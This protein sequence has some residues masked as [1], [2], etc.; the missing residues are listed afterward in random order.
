MAINSV[1]GYL[2]LVPFWS[3]VQGRYFY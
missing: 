1:F 2:I 3:L